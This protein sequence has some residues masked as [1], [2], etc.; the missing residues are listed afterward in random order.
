[1]RHFACVNIFFLSCLSAVLFSA[2]AVPVRDAVFTVPSEEEIRKKWDTVK[3]PGTTVWVDYIPEMDARGEVNFVKGT[4][5]FE[6]AIPVQTEN[7]SDMGAQKI[8]LCALRIL[9]AETPGGTEILKDQIRDRKGNILKQQNI[10]R[11]VAEE[12]VVKLKKE[13]RPYIA[14]DGVKRVK[15][16]ASIPLV[17][18]HIEVRARQYMEIVRNYAR[19][20]QLDTRLMMAMIHAESHFNPLARSPDGALG[21]MQLIP[22]YGGKEAY[23]FVYGEDRIPEESYFFDPEKNIELGTA[24]YHLLKNRHFSDIPDQRK[25]RYIAVCAYNWGPGRLRSL[26][27]AYPLQKMNAEKA[28]AL[29]E[30]KI[31]QETAEYLNDVIRLTE[32]YG[33]IVSEK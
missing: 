10:D 28:F 11:F 1:M 9:G 17:P 14:G 23:A 2:C 4:V 33:K 21:L 27:N 26:V 7:I 13:N 8:R 32:A 25:K 29:L 16:E 12:I 5:V 30:G 18:N 15:M 24:Y 20:F 6:T 22:H 19:R 31:P 3:L